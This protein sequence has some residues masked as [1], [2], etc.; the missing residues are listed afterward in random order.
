MIYLLDTHAF[1]WAVLETDK[2]SKNVQSL[3][4]DINNE[5]YV[6]LYAKRSS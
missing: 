5:I 1:I 2:L 4:T 3:I 6:R